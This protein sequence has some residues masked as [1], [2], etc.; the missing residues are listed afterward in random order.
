MQLEKENKELKMVMRKL[1][2]EMG[3]A[4]ML[5]GA[6]IYYLENEIKDSNSNIINLKGD[7]NY[8]CK[9]FKDLQEYNHAEVLEKKEIFMEDIERII[10]NS[11]DKLNGSDNIKFDI[12]VSAD[13]SKL[14]IYGEITKINQVVINILKN[15]IEALNGQLGKRG[16][17]IKVYVDKAIDYKANCEKKYNKNM[18]CIK[19]S[20]NGKGIPE[21]NLP[22]I[23]KPMYTYGKEN[24]TGLGLCIVKKIVEDH[25]GKIEAESEPDVGTNIKIYM[26]AFE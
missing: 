20:D 17:Y 15:S 21:K 13:I 11:F 6:S 19:I 18:I 24:G 25:G 2:H 26:P 9:L 8:I 12:N 7:Y 3:N 5:L 16:K 10:I 23:F 4:L 22:E 1:S 14:K